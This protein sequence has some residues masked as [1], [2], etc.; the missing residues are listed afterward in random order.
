[1]AKAIPW[2]RCFGDAVL[3]VGSEAFSESLGILFGV[4][5]AVE[6]V[7]GAG[8]ADRDVEIEGFVVYS[9]LEGYGAGRSA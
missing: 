8:D 7:E 5:V 9:G 2:R 1:L 4:R 3:G 6:D